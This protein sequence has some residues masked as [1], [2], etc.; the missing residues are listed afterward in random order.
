MKANVLLS[1]VYI[2]K[3][4]LVSKDDWRRWAATV[5]TSNWHFF[6][7]SD[8]EEV[9]LKGFY[10]RTAN[11]PTT[12][13]TIFLY[14]QQQLLLTKRKSKISYWSFSP[15]PPFLFFLWYRTRTTTT[16]SLFEGKKWHPF[17]WPLII[18]SPFFFL[19]FFL[20]LSFSIIII[21]ISIITSI[22]K[23]CCCWLIRTFMFIKWQLQY[24]NFKLRRACGI[25]CMNVCE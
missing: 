18:V 2:L 22:Y 23:F 8:E 15:L 4:K 7:L 24:E 12:K 3:Q 5:P 19:L 14:Q 13:N 20:V 25:F 9:S 17:F 10:Y 16:S 1:I 21:D 6:L 11:L